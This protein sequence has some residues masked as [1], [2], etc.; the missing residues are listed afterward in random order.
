MKK[1]LLTILSTCAIFSAN[2]LY[3]KQV[4]AID[5]IEAIVNDD[6]ITTSELNHNLTIVKLQ[7]AQNHSNLP[8]EHLL[9]KQV[10]DQLINKKLQLQIAK[11][12]SIDISEEDLD[13]TI[14]SVAKRNNMTVDALYQQLTHDGLSRAEYRKDLREQMLLQK[15][16]QQEIINRISISAD[17]INNFMHSKTWQS[18]ADKEY[19]LEDILIPLTEAPTPEEISRAKSHAQALM[20]KINKGQS[21]HSVAQSESSDKHAFEGGDL[22]WRKLPEIPSAFAEHV[23]N[24]QTNQIAGPIQT[25]NGFHILHLAAA[26]SIGEQATPDRKQI[27]NLLLQRK[28]EEAVQNWVSKL[29]SQAYIV[30]DLEKA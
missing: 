17:E 23:V 11:Q 4:E 19:H 21:F 20:L 9:K 13:S 5:K 27:K 18:N 25:A 26:R 10:L 29:R 3:A 12:A 1:A 30:S 6:V 24:M 16:Q 14:L 7:I 22:G 8:A 2:H 15:L 28:F